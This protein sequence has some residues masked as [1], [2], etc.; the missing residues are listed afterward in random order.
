M[1]NP[2]PLS[3]PLV[4]VCVGSLSE[5]IDAARAGADRVELCANLPEGGTT[6]SA[7]AIRQARA[8]LDAGLFVMIRPRGG[9]FLYSAAEIASMEYDIDVAAGEGAD[10][11]VLGVL[12]A[13]GAIDLRAVGRLC[14]RADPLPVTF[15]RA[16]DLARSPAQ[17]L[18]GLA[19]AGV[20]RVLTSALENSVHDGVVRLEELVRSAAEGLRVVA[21]CGRLSP[22][23]V[24]HVVE[25]SGVTEVHVYSPEKQA[26]PMEF[27][28][29]DVPMGMAYEPDDYSRVRVDG[30]RIRSLIEL[31]S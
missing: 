7:G 14:R 13:D 10:G 19:D 15:H 29:P 18:A 21:A 16:F 26:G 22:Q 20:S 2:T 30:V 24:A 8:S 31:L 27:R 6:P 4:E 1:E 3:R 28:R 5:A 17:A 12:Q 25:R 23:E 9:D 11:V